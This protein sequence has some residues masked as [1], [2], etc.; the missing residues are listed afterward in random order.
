M[1]ILDRFGS[2][3]LP[4][5]APRHTGGT[6]GSQARFI[7]LPGGGVYDAGGSGVL[8]PRLPADL[9]Y[10]CTVVG[11]TAARLRA[12]LDELRALRGCSDRLYRRRI[13]NSLVEQWA[14]A[15]LM[16]IDFDTQARHSHGLFQPITMLFALTSV[17]RGI[18]HGPSWTLDSG[19]YLDS[20]LYFDMADRYALTTSPK[21]LTISNGG[22]A[23]VDEILITV[24][25]GATPVTGLTIATGSCEL[26]YSGTIASNKSLVIDT[27]PLTRSVLNDGVGDWKS[28]ATGYGHAS[29][30]W[31]K[32]AVG[33]NTVTVTRTG[34]G[35]DTYVT[36]EF[37]DAWE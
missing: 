30:V 32:L 16:Q 11:S 23:P 1:Y 31:L 36:F 33:A 2:T 14:T 35:T 19:E 13:D 9:R 18:G 8:A 17:W 34:G 5:G 26:V 10:D 3:A 27:A 37:W 20:G 28:L 21:T 22:N 15:R 6:F 12:T 24:E 29:D 25:A 4:V 7:R